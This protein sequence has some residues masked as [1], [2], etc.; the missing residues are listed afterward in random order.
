MPGDGAV[1]VI[2]PSGYA[3]PRD[4]DNIP[5]FSYIHQPGGTPGE[6]GL[7]YRS[8]DPTGP[9][10]ASIDFTL[11]KVDEPDDFDVI[12]FTD[13]QPESRLELD[14]VRDTAVAR[15]MAIPAA[16]GMTTGDVSFDDLSLYARSNGIVG[17]IG[18]PWYTAARKEAVFLIF[19]QGFAWFALWMAGLVLTPDDRAHFLVL[20]RRQM[21]SAVHR[22]VN[23]LLLPD[24]G[25]SVARI[26]AALYLDESTVAEHRALYGQRGRTG[27]ESLGYTGRVSRLSA[28]QRAAL[29]DWI[30]AEV[31]QTA[32]A[33]CAGVQARLAVSHASHAMAR[34]L[35]QTGFVFK[36][37]ECVPAQADAAV[38]QAFLDT[39]LAPLMQAA[40]PSAPPYFVDGCHPSC[41]GRPA[42]GWIRR[43]ATVELKSNHGR[44]RIS[45]NGALSWPGRSLI[46]RE[47][48]KITS[49][50]MIRLFTGLEAR[51]PEA[52]ESAVVRDNAR[53]NRS[54]ELKAGLDQPGG[55]VRLVD[56]PSY[57]PSLN[58][59]ERFRHFRKRKV[60]FNRA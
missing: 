15:A 29:S 49:A 24:E 35:G 25:W 50:A 37:P 23:V 7:R 21:N 1:F 14:H 30:A 20:M 52:A 16:F 58:L 55:R 26:A 12:L 34:L 28:G 47:E 6:L 57:A 19:R 4:A 42:H 46:H 27:V 54:R 33:V 32:R 8:L 13:P 48:E 18:L 3:P 60:L 43:G 56:L 9:L 31:P 11:A 39:T 45:I 41:T 5:R 38:Q 10:P 17:R 36:K 40:G 53:D 44:T 22:R 59:I 51:H 2:K